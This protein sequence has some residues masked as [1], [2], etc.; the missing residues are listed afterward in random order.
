MSAASEAARRWFRRVLETASSADEAGGSRA[1]FRGNYR[2]AR[3]EAA[4]LVV[5]R[6]DPGPVEAF[7]RLAGLRSRTQVAAACAG[8][9]ALCCLL[10]LVV[11]LVGPFVFAVCLLWLI[12]EA[13]RA[14]VRGPR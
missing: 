14:A 8:I 10:G 13:V 6:V 3:E 12:L 1:T 2:A 7:R 11:V 4:R 9:S 5:E